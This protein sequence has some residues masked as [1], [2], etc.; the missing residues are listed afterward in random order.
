[1]LENFSEQVQ[2]EVTVRRDDDGSLWAEVKQLPGCF[3][4]GSDMDELQDNLAEAIGLYLSTPTHQLEMK[5]E[6]MEQT[7]VVSEQRFKVLA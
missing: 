1:M 7:G 5:P 4:T 6:S 2:Y 3:A